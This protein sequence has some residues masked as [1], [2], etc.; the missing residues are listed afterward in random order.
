MQVYIMLSTLQDTLLFVYEFW[1]DEFVAA[2]DAYA[3]Y[4]AWPLNLFLPREAST[5]DASKTE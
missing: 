3:S 5:Q 4:G 2:T 1:H